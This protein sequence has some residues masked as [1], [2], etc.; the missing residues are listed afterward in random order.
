MH[1][2]YRTAIQPNFNSEEVYTTILGTSKLIEY[3]RLEHMIDK[4]LKLSAD[5]SRAYLTRLELLHPTR[6]KIEAL[7][8]ETLLDE[9]EIDAYLDDQT[10]LDEETY[11]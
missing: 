8:A 2:N 4:A 3:L 6:D 10:Y 11:L 7:I 5:S 1:N 9:S